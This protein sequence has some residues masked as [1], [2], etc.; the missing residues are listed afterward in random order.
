MR[1]DTHQN[2]YQKKQWQMAYFILYSDSLLTQ[3]PPVNN[4]GLTLT[5]KT[6]YPPQLNQL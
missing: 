3:P 4:A 2:C 6:G 1:E 5:V